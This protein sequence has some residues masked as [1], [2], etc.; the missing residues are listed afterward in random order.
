VANASVAFPIYTVH[1]NRN[2]LGL[3]IRMEKRKRK[4]VDAQSTYMRRYLGFVWF[5]GSIALISISE[6]VMTV[7]FGYPLYVPEPGQ[8]VDY[9]ALLSVHQEPNLFLSVN[10]ITTWL[11]ALAA[12]LF[13]T[14]WRGN[15]GPLLAKWVLLLGSVA[16]VGCG[17]VLLILNGNPP[18]TMIHHISTIEFERRTYHLASYETRIPEDSVWDIGYLV[19]DCECGQEVC[20]AEWHALRWLLSGYSAGDN[21]YSPRL[22]TNH[23]QGQLE[24][25]VGDEIVHVVGSSTERR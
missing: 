4:N 10:P 15:A 12:G 16:H 5:V 9:E 18:G 22:V 1:V 11:C 3:S 17:F 8:I 24:I 23:E 20:H 21:T 2:L 7:G 14:M 6:L 19:F 25:W 13:L